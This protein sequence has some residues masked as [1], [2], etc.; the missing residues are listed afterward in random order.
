MRD[1]VTAANQNFIE[2]SL[3]GAE[4]MGE[5]YTSDAKIY[6]PGGDMVSGTKAIGEF[7]K[8]AYGMEIK[9]AELD[10]VD[11]EAASDQIIVVGQYTLYGD[12]NAE[13]DKGKYMVIW[14]Q[15][16]RNWKLYR[17]IWDT[18]MPAQ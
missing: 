3:K 5:L 13:L 17:D 6:P 4:T 8:G 10:T 18:G 11:A 9:A 12:G 7:W 1:A 14:K 2:I 15:D 16:G